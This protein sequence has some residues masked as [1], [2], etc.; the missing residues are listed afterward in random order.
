MGETG[1]NFRQAGL[2]ADLAKE[3]VHI[4]TQHPELG[5]RSLSEF[6]RHAII[7][8]LRLTKIGLAVDGL[9]ATSKLGHDVLLGVLKDTLP[10]EYSEII[11]KHLNLTIAD[12]KIEHSAIFS[13]NREGIHGKMNK[14]PITASEGGRPR[15]MKF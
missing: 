8:Q 2:P 7:E 11:I 9:Y 3:I 4:I 1:G 15:Q 6:A 10:R 12:S 5:F 14:W 13:R